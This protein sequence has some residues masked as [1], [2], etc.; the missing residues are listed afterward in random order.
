MT[1][2]ERKLQVLSAVVEAYIR[3]G[4]PVGSKMICELMGNAVS[5]AT[6]RNEMADLAERGLLEQPHT[7]AGRVPTN[8]G[9]R[10]YIGSRMAREPLSQADRLNIDAMLLEAAGSDPEHL[11]EGA[12]QALASVTHCAAVVTMPVAESTA[13]RS[14]QVVPVGRRTVVVVLMTS[15]GILKNKVC[16][17][18]FDL[19][20]DVLRV[21]SRLT[22]EKIAGRALADISVAYIQT[23][24][25]SI[26]EFV[27]LIAPV[28][29]AILDAVQDAEK[30]DACVAGQANLLTHPEY[31][32]TEAR[33]VLDFLST[34]E[35]IAALMNR[36]PAGLRVCIGRETDQPA[37]ESS[38]ILTAG[39][40]IGGA[41]CG[42]LAVIGPTRMN[43]P[44]LISYLEYFSDEVGTLLTEMLRNE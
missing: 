17:C 9:Y 7:S 13:V 31:S 28:L 19:T 5:S 36:S 18:G 3:T 29:L 23:L 25:A 34:P 42:H 40:R 16:R 26:G 20:P 12:A 35:P 10:L 33:R 1:L 24:A 14:V 39:Y 2:G 11:V 30:A 43:Y 6:I 21:I 4:E 41:D 32:D 15:A 37:L 22:S 27:F 44:K 8:R 38:S